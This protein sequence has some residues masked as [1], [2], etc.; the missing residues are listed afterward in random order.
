MINALVWCNEKIRRPAVKQD[1]KAKQNRGN[2]VSVEAPQDTCDLGRRRWKVQRE[3]LTVGLDVG[4]KISHYCVLNEEAEVVERGKL[5]TTPAGLQPWLEALPAGTRVVLET[6]THSS[7]ISRLIEQAGQEALVAQPRKMPQIYA[8][9]RKNDRRDAEKLA[10]TGRLDPNSM[11]PIRHRSAEQQ[12]DLAVIQA[13]DALVQVRTQLINTVRGLVKGTGERLKGCSARSFARQVEDQIPQRLRAALLPLVSE[14][15]SLSEQ[16]ERYDAEVEK[17]AQKK[18]PETELLRQVS[19]VG[20]VTSL[21]FVLTV[22]DRW[23]FRH[24]RDVGPFL[25]LVPAQDESG[26]SSPQLRISKA[27]NPY[28]RR[29]L[30]GSANYILGP[31]G[32]DC[33]LRRW[34]KKLSERG[35]KNARKRAK[36]AVARRLAVLLHKL[37]LS[38]EVY[39]PLPEKRMA[40]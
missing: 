7:W 31:F 33:E 35:D 9:K 5:K 34:G 32:P 19:G 30:V 14:V 6:G 13:R 15:T 40:A 36:V 27:G 16:I 23:R 3:G 24:S 26:E 2:E 20:P 37:W 38:G 22:G 10:R 28:L 29:L 1:N 21:A 39:E 8:S 25:G 18:Y 4:D 11:G 12:A 17:L